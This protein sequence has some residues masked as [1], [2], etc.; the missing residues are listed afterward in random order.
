MVHVSQVSFCL[1]D[2]NMAGKS[3]YI[4]KCVLL[5]PSLA[6]RRLHCS[7]PKFRNVS[8]PITL[9]PNGN[10]LSSDQVEYKSISSWAELTTHIEVFHVSQGDQTNTAHVIDL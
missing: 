8:V 4:K 7:I 9:L 3:T 5:Y 10:F 1:I 6:G 2:R